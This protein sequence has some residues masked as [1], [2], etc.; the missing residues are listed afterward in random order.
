MSAKICVT[1]DVVGH[2][3]SFFKHLPGI[4]VLSALS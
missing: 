2:I 3:G 1:V 4:R